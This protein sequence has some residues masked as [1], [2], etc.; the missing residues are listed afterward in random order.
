MRCFLCSLLFMF[1]ILFYVL[2][3]ILLC[4]FQL[5]ISYNT[6]PWHHSQDTGRHNK[7][8]THSLLQGNSPTMIYWPHPFLPMHPPPQKKKINSK[9]VRPAPPPPPHPPLL[10]VTH[11]KILEDL[12]ILPLNCT[13]VQKRKDSVFNE[14]KDFI[15]N[16]K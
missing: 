3:S 15:S 6:E 2:N 8:I 13:L 1:Y 5:S 4:S 7:N 10:C 12:T 11:L 16:I 14:T 9:S